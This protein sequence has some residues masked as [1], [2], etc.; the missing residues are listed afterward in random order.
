MVYNKPQYTYKK[1]EYNMHKHIADKWSTA[2]RSGEYEK[3][4]GQLKCSSI[5]IGGVF[6]CCLGV[7]CELAI[8]DGVPIE[9]IMEEDGVPVEEEFGFFDGYDGVLPPSV[10]DWAGMDS[11]NAEGCYARTMEKGY[12]KIKSLAV[13][14][15]D[16]VSFYQIADTIDKYW[17]VL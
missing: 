11:D 2:L 4:E 15:D 12:T 5:I 16:G 9:T 6:H 13:D 14:N 1:G 17:E 3:C 8:E 7:L 10:I